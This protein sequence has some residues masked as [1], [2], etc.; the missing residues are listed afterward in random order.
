MSGTVYAA[1]EDIFV[2]HAW[3]PVGREIQGLPIRMEKWGVFIIRR[4]DLRAKIEGKG[5][6]AFFIK[7]C[8]PDVV[9]TNPSGPVADEV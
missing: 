6:F 5:P 3:P 8:F 2:T 1:Q 4:I 7:L 9:T